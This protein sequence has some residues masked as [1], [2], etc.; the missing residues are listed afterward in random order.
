MELFSEHCKFAP[1]YKIFSCINSYKY[2]DRLYI[3]F[4]NKQCRTVQMIANSMMMMGYGNWI[5]FGLKIRTKSLSPLK[6]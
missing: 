6:F 4:Y 3:G 5:V 1:N 2:K